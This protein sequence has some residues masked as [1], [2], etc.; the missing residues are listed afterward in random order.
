MGQLRMTSLSRQRANNHAGSRAMGQPG[1]PKSKL[2]NEEAMEVGAMYSAREGINRRW[3][4]RPSRLSHPRCGFV[5]DM[6]DLAGANPQFFAH[7]TSTRHAH[8]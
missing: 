6:Q 2:M 3:L 5:P 7:S 8:R 4:S 1:Q